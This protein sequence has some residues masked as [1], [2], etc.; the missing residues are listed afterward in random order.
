MTAAALRQRARADRSAPTP[1]MSLWRLE[2][3]RLTRTP[4][5]IALGAIFL[6]IGFI[7]P[8]ATKY[9]NDLISRVAHG[10]KITLPPPTAADG[11]G[12]VADICRCA[13]V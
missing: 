8:V 6:F 3:L 10:P 7:E 5:A 13:R 12:S 11:I 1:R 9:E 4:R 2:W